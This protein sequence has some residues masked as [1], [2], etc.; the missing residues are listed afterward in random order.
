MR[1]AS[2][3]E[4]QVA[5]GWFVG[6]NRERNALYGDRAY[7]IGLWEVNIDRGCAYPRRDV[8]EPCFRRV[9][10]PR[11][12][13]GSVCLV[14]PDGPLYLAGISSFERIT[15]AGWTHGAYP[16]VASTLSDAD[17]ARCEQIAPTA[18]DIISG[19]GTMC[20]QLDAGGDGS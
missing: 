9:G 6:T 11:K 4:F 18:V 1:A 10:E 17:E 12:D 13:V 8:T 19:A 7:V 2:R 3:R 16:T 5:N 15:G 14:G 20:E